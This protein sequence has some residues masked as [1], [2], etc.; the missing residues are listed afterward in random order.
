M[1]NFLLEWD[2][3]GEHF[4]ETGVDH[5]VLFVMDDDGDYGDGV[6]WNGLTAISESPEGGEPTPLY[7][8]NIKYLNLISNEEFGATIEAYM[9]PE[10]F[11]ECD[12][13]ANA[14]GLKIGQQARAK[15]ALAY[16]TKVGNDTEGDTYDEKLHVVYGCTAAPSSKDYATV[17]E[18]PEAMTFSWEISTV[19]VDVE[20]DGVKYKPT[21]HVEITKSAAGE[22]WNAIY[23]ELFGGEGESAK[24]TLLMPADIY[25]KLNAAG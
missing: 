7:A 25:A 22:K 10:E 23:T 15:F 11:E 2:K 16:L 12:G 6:V 21:A 9:W 3:A 1:A 17:N 13:I 24:P 5:G 20:I 18:T 8:D 14:G 19:P 4:Y